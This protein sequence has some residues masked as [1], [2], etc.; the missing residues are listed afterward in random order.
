MSDIGSLEAML[1]NCGEEKLKGLVERFLSINNY[2]VSKWESTADGLFYAKAIDLQRTVDCLV[3][4]RQY[5]ILAV[6]TVEMLHFSENVKASKCHCGMFIATSKFSIEAKEFA[7]ALNESGSL[8]V[9]LVEGNTMARYL[10]QGNLFGQERTQYNTDVMLKYAME[11][12]Q[13]LRG[14]KKLIRVTFPDG[15]VLCDSAPTQTFLQTISRIGPERVKSLGLEVCH[16]PLVS[17]TLNDKYKE[18]IKPI[19]DG[20][21][22]MAQSDTEQKFRQL[23]S[24]NSQLLLNLILE[25]G[26]DL[27]IVTHTK[28]RG[29]RKVKSQLM[30]TLP[31]GRV[32]AGESQTETFVAFIDY[33]GIDNVCRKHI[34]VANKHLV[35]ATRLYNGQVQVRNG[36]WLTIPNTTKDKYKI[37]KIIGSVFHMKIDVVIV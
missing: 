31:D 4:V 25:I 36:K 26:P 28:K 13:R 29:S 37:L 16:I 14:K 33:V 5:A 21:Y 1:C 22:V 17:Q 19:G 18:W 35:T 24:I 34:S 7:K 20:W 32:F 3:A 12:T 23:H 15:T 9:S 2:S 10:A 6:D 8:C 27:P 30:I 11:D